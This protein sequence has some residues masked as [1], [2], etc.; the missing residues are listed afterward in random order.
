MGALE[1]GSVSDLGFDG[2]MV[3]FIAAGAPV[4]EL[5]P[6]EVPGCWRRCGRVRCGTS[7]PSRVT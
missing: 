7:S 1:D 6:V 3:G 5:R 2:D 4:G